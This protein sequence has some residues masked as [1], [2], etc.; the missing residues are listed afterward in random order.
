M[1]NSSG[2]SI[3]KEQEEMI[4]DNIKLAYFIKLKWIKQLDGK[5]E[6]SEIESSCLFGLLK[7][8]THFDPEKKI[9]FATF[10]TKCMDNEV[11]MMIRQAKRYTKT[12]S[13][14]EI[15]KIDESGNEF[16]VENLVPSGEFEEDIITRIVIN[17]RMNEITNARDKDILH[18]LSLSY[19]QK[20]IAKELGISQSYVSR[21]E[22]KLKKKIFREV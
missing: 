13:L 19:T 18:L 8:V 1:Y 2:I 16:I 15:L 10:A 4:N 7:S 17:A 14:S 11:L 20:Q 9:K 21:I 22:K 6:E 5:Y 3:T 12:I